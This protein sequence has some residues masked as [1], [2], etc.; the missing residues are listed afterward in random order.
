MKTGSAREM[1]GFRNAENHR[2]L[3]GC[4]GAQPNPKMFD[5]DL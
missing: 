4:A 1:H 5:D 2:V 3:E